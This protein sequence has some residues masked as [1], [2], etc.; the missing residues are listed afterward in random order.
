MFQVGPHEVL[1]SKYYEVIFV[2][3]QLHVYVPLQID[4]NVII[5]QHGRD[6]V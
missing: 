4:E 1:T 5:S 2:R 3:E 6:S